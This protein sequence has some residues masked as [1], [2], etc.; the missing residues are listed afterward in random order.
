MVVSHIRTLAV[1]TAFTLVASTASAAGLEARLGHSVVRAGEHVQLQ[2]RAPIDGSVATPDL[3]P[4]ER[5]FEILG[6]QQSQRITVVNGRR[7]ASVDWTVTLLPRS[8]GEIVIPPLHAGAATSEPLRIRVAEAAPPPSR[9]DAPDLFVESTVDQISPYVQGEV[10]YTVKVYDGIGIRGGGLT[11]PQ[12]ENARVTVAGEGRT[13]EETV[14]GRRY[15]VHERE[16]VLAP[17]ASGKMVVAPVTLEA[18]IADPGARGRSPVADFFGGQDPFGATFGRFGSGLFD[19]MMNPGRQIRVRSNAIE[20]DVQARPDGAQ[21]WFLP[22]KHVEIAEAF[23]PA[24]PS[25]RVG[26]A[27][28]RTVT[29]RALG[30]SAEQLPAF[31]IPAVEGVRQYDEGSRDGTLPTDDGTVSVREQT[32]AL[33]PSSP[34]AVI[35]P[36]VQVTW[37]DATNEVERTAELPAREIQVL[38]AMGA[39]TTVPAPASAPI[40]KPA[41]TN[42]EPSVGSTEPAAKETGLLEGWLPALAALLLGL[43]GAWV[44]VLR[45]R[46]SVGDPASEP[47]A[48]HL[49]KEVQKACGAADPAGTRDALVRWARARFGVGAPAN[50]RMIAL[51]LGHDEFSSEAL[52]LDR[53][54]YAPGADAFD[55]ARFWQQLRLAL[56]AE[57]AADRSTAPQVLP[58]LYPSR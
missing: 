11:A 26:E 27:V 2:L 16:Y 55:G 25:F 48:P 57:G 35:L 19:Q 24:S 4:L 45:R 20:I 42:P 8:T 56:R 13:Y 34:G 6:T 17:Q 40:A 39:A 31:E 43:G 15:Q 18:R 29:L 49:L 46:R 53:S 54:L 10:R 3:S 14:K 50:P 7:E 32:V 36:P 5:D 33:V 58:E 28:K 44:V 51:R 22:A 21:G 23:E 37:W 9:A 41:V 52:R 12:V 1:V 47:G 38:P 30:A